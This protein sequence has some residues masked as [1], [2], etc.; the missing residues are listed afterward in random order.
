VTLNSEKSM[1][2]S[3]RDALFLYAAAFLLAFGGGHW[4]LALPFIVNLFGGSDTQVGMCLAANMGMYALSVMIA[5]PLIIRYNLKRILQVGTIGMTFSTLL[6]CII[7]ALTVNR[8]DLPRPTW[9]LILTSAFFGISQ[10]GFWPPLM[11]WLST[12][13]LSSKL[14]RRLSW[15]SVAWALGSFL[16][17]YSAGRLVEIHPVWPIA[18]AVGIL[19][20]CFLSVSAPPRPRSESYN[21]TSGSLIQPEK[22]HL[23]PCFRW[24]ARIALFA[25]FLSF[26]IA[27]TQFPIYFKVELGHSES[28]YGVFLTLSSIAMF[29]N[30]LSIG[31]THAWHYRFS[32]FIIAQVFM[33]LFQ[34]TVLFCT[35]LYIFYF[36]SL[37][38]G[39]G[40]AF[41][42]SSHLYY[43][44]AGGAKRYALM[45]IHEFTLAS[46]FVIGALLGGALS[47]HYNRLAPYKLGAAV[48]TLAILAQIILF[49]LYRSKMLCAQKHPASVSDPG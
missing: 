46:G 1:L 49:I 20:I 38:L 2:A 48:L 13:C 12:G 39:L 21:L 41:C 30:Y 34:L 5:T 35:R 26:G 28:I 45:A 23:L 25:G 11:A 44:S 40:S 3:D 22:H 15:F 32:F 27:R 7:I 36:V 24:M 4:W 9:L 17:P 47:D 18:I 33:L 31:R 6:M 19:V 42:Y 37:I 14:N 29:I 10:A 43:S 16:C 8:Y